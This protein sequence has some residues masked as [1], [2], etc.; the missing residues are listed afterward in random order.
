MAPS[1]RANFLQGFSY[2]KLS[3]RRPIT[4]TSGSKIL[5]KNILLK[6]STVLL[7]PYPYS[8]VRV[9]DDI[10][11]PCLQAACVHTYIY[12]CSGVQL[13]AW[14]PSASRWEAAGHTHVP[15]SSSSVCTS[16][17]PERRPPPTLCQTRCLL[18]D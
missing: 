7:N 1:H 14:L 5:K 16:G 17:N 18:L 9:W 8:H 13:A 6:S 4:I 3:D 11:R 15:L 12:T 10:S 2:T